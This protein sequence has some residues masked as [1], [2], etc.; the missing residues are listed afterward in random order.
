M[1]ERKP[2][3]AAVEETL[4]EAGG[5]GREAWQAGDL[6]KAEAHFLTVWN[7]IPE[8]RLEYDFA[9]SIAVS[10][11]QFYRDTGQAEKAFQWLAVAREA[12][13]PDANPHTEFLAATVHYE[14]GQF[15]Q[16]YALF[17]TLY[18]Q[19]HRRPFEDENPAYLD[20]Y[21]KKAEG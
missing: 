10:L 2:L 1:S 14:A 15:E 20:F 11:T 5:L 18:R 19:Y 13:G 12:Y 3:P 4:Y 17:D 9:D 16:A 21:L 7:S 6:E 8:P